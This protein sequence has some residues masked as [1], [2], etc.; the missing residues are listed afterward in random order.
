MCEGNRCK[1]ES[2]KSKGNEN[3]LFLI[4]SGQLSKAMDSLKERGRTEQ[5]AG[6][7]EMSLWGDLGQKDGGK[8]EREV[9]K[10]AARPAMLCEIWNDGTEKKT[11]GRAEGGRIEDVTIFIGSDQ[12]KQD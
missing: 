2:T 3:V 7:V 6:R 4:H 11:G 5:S 12:N 8:K 10:M 9:Y 1:S